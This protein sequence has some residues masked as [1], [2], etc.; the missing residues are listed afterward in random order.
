MTSFPAKTDLEKPAFLFGERK[1]G[2]K[3]ISTY[4]RFNA[5]GDPEFSRLRDPT[6]LGLEESDVPGDSLM[7]ESKFRGTR[8]FVGLR[9]EI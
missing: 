1:R 6:R 9:I 8:H 3:T 7:N 4:S 5:K 2:A